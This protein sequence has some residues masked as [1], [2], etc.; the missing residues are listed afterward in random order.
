MQPARIEID[1]NL[2]VRRDQTVVFQEE[3]LG[4]AV[5]D[6]VTVFESEAGIV[7]DAVVD[8]I[9]RTLGLVYLDVDWPS[10]HVEEAS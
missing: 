6:R 10:L 9:D 2:R 8:E 7:G 5:G 1:P 3:A 4:V